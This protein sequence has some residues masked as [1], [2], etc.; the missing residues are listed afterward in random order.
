MYPSSKEN[1]SDL[2]L[3]MNKLTLKFFGK[4]MVNSRSVKLLENKKVLIKKLL[5]T[6]TGK[7]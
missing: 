1:I 3:G 4:I 2:E 5:T 6:K 7:V